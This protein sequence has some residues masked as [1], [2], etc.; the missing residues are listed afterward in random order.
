MNYECPAGSAIFFHGK[1]V[2]RRSRVATGDTACRSAKRLRA[3][4]DTLASAEGLH[5]KCFLLYRV[6]SR[7]TSVNPGL[8][9]SVRVQQQLTRLNGF[10]T[11]TKHLLILIP[12]RDFM[13][14]G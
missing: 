13:W 10:L 1:P 12:S 9:T 2:S 5:L 7:H 6:K 8:P 3:S 14:R 4:R 11:T